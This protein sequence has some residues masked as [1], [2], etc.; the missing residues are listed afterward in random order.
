MKRCPGGIEPTASTVTASRAG[1]YTTDTSASTRIRT[2]N[3]KLEAWD[4]V[5]FTIE[6]KISQ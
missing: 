2:W 4:D 1:R 5:R 3:P 6:A